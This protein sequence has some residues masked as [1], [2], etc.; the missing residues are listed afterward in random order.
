LTCH[1]TTV[2]FGL[3]NVAAFTCAVDASRKEGCAINVEVFKSNVRLFFKE[4]APSNLENELA[5]QIGEMQGLWIMMQC[6]HQGTSLEPMGDEPMLRWT[7][8]RWTML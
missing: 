4:N 2:Q 3:P 1:G 6:A 7:M 5:T 8:L